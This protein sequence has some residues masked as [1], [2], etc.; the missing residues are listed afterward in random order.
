MK[1]DCNQ[2]ILFNYVT[3]FVATTVS[4]L[5]RLLS[6]RAAPADFSLQ[7]LSYALAFFVGVLFFLGFALMDRSVWRSGV[8]LTT[9]SARASL[10][11]PVILSWLLLYQPEP[12]WLPVGIV[13]ASLALIV[14]PA[15]NEKHE[16]VQLTAK[17]DSQR[18]RRA[19][20]LLLTVFLCYGVS[21]YSLKVAQHS[22]EINMKEGM[23]SDTFLDTLTAVIFFSA[24]LLSLLWCLATGSFRKNPAGWR[25]L[26]GG[27]VLG[28]VNLLG[29]SSSLRALSVMS[30]N[31]YYP[32]YN[33]GIVLVATFVGVFFFKEKLKWVQYVG[34]ALSILAIILF[35]R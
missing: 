35:F 4:I 31:L 33:I 8:A 9:V 34:I 10:I 20:I 7:P 25:S 2:V 1:I 12:E 6:G 11:L 13:L 17:T 29:T 28:V 15:E 24:S 21:D 32:L 5:F 22:V 18:R 30:T 23:L 3:A 16:N 27:V 26:L 19:V 14:L